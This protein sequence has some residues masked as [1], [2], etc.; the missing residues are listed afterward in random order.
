MLAPMQQGM[1]FSS[2]L[3]A[4]S[5][6][7]IE[8]IVFE[9]QEDLEASIFEEAWR[10]IISRHKGFRTSF[11]WEGLKTPLQTVHREVPF[12]FEH[13]DWRDFSSTEQTSRVQGLLLAERRRGFDHAIPPLMRLVLCRLGRNQFRLI[14]TFEH[15]LLDGRSFSLVIR[16]VFSIYEALRQGR[17]PELPSV[18]SYRE[19]IEWLERQHFSKSESYWRP[20]LQGFTAPTPLVVDSM[21]SAAASTEAVD[22]GEQFLRLSRPLT[23]ELERLAARHQ[24]TLNTLVQGGWALLLSRYSGEE[25]VVFGVTRAGRKSIVEGADSMIGLFINTLPFRARLEPETALL[26]WLQELRGQQLSIRDHEHTPLSQI[27]QW[28][29]VPNGAP[30]FESVLV[31][32]RA[33]LDSGLRAQGGAWLNRHFQV[34]D[35]TNFP[36]TLFAY[37]EA[38]LLFKISYD[39]RRLEPGVVARLGAHLETLLGG[40]AANP[41]QKLSLLPLLPEAERRQLLVEWNRTEQDYPTDCCFHEAIEA[42]AFATPAAVALVCGDEQITYQ[43]LNERAS[44]LAR[45]LQRLE[46][47][48]E[49]LVGVCLDVSLEMVVALLGVLKAGGAYVPLD[50][51]Y[52][53]ERLAFMLEDAQAR[54][55][56]TQQKLAVTFASSK[57]TVVCLDDGTTRAAIDDP[58]APEIACKAAPD[59]LAYVLYTSGSTGQPKGVMVTHRNIL[60][61]FAGMDQHLGKEPGVWL[62]VTSI[63]FDISVLEQFWTLARGFK[64]VLQRREENLASAV[65]HQITRHRITHLQCTPSMAEMLT[66]DGE[67]RQTLGSLRKLLLGGEALSPE[68]LQQIDTSGE[69]LNMYGPT[70]TT[71]WST[72]HKVDKRARRIPIGRPIANTEIYIL[73]RHLQPLPI[74]VPGEL[75]IGGAG[76]A[77]GYLKRNELTVEKFIPHPFKAGSGARLYRTG[78]RA[79]YLAD[80]A[81]EFL[82]RLDQQVKLRGFR[83]ELGEIEAALRQHAGVKECVVAACAVTP[84]D[85]RLVAYVVPVAGSAPALHSLRE[86]LKQKLPDYMLPAFFLLLNA[87]PLTPNGKIN[88]NALPAPETGLQSESAAVPPRSAVEKKLAQIWLDVLGCKEVGIHDNFFERGGHSLLAMQVVSQVRSA[89]DKS[90]SIVQLYQ[91]PTIHALARSLNQRTL[92]SRVAMNG[93]DR[94]RFRKQVPWPVRPRSRRP[95]AGAGRATDRG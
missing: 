39:Q 85:V 84:R 12:P 70:E 56:L 49:V 80:G 62:A 61:F 38:E 46:V 53:K 10:R 28:S 22:Y 66:R 79:R 95:Q 18:R 88:R 65:A 82:G 40:M 25:D 69:I 24:L 44:Q 15:A 67:A 63:S 75:F 21:T 6:V 51:G 32:E 43:E 34:I 47:G 59:N 90:F 78:D 35:Q 29:Q 50:P 55:L 23:T 37:G 72:V 1:L 19:Y 74:G 64:V 20:L 30:L 48:P 52:P 11:H 5:G 31:F 33:T 68:L 83:I 7:N 36:L 16:E 58:Q 76:V 71:V 81:I 41:H 87:L 42:R 77:R 86:Y 92:T 13:N 89:L 57:T 2:L 8:Q 94:A 9:L 4:H 54:V 91:H 17:E 27:Q 93:F 60:N 14:W 3:A 26:P 73:D 45:Y